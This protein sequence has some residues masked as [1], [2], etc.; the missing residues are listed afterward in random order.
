MRFSKILIIMAFILVSFESYA[1]NVSSTGTAKVKDGR[2]RE[3]YYKA[4]ENSVIGAI[5]WYYR[6]NSIR[7]IEVTGDFIRFVNGYSI[8]STDLSEDNTTV[9][10]RMRLNLDEKAL[11]D[12]NLII[13]Q[14]TDPVVYIFRGIDNNIIPA[15]TIKKIIESHL[16]SSQFSLAEQST[17]L[18]DMRGKFDNESIEKSFKNLKETDNLFIFDFQP[19]YDKE[20]FVTQFNSCELTTTISIYEKKGEP[21][22]LQVVTGDNLKNDYNCYVS[23]INQ[24][25]TNLMSYIREN[26]IK[27]PDNA[28]KLSKYR[29]NLLNLN[30]MVTAKNVINLLIQRGVIKTYKTLSYSQKIMA[31][32]VET[33]FKPDNLLRKIQGLEI[34]NEP[35]ITDSGSAINI[36]FS[37]QPVISDNVSE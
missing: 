26:M 24:S 25:V 2:L 5:K 8:L 37:K 18:V 22:R 6:Q 20:M 30:N 13:N 14:H 9:T 35:V 32:E 19:V 21:K 28:A 16:T 1:I 23:S 34:E 17:F 33:F 36:D 3:A 31:F 10:M 7:G 12:A 27:L 15:N 29:I 4:M 11:K